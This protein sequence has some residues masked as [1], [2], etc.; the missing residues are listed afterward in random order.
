MLRRAALLT[1][2]ALITAKCVEFQLHDITP[3]TVLSRLFDCL[4]ILR[5]RL[6]GF[7][8]GNQHVAPQI[9]VSA[10]ESL[11]HLMIE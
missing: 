4:L 9:R 2:Q 6:G 5:A 10:D 11:C 7:A 8:L 3:G 1:A